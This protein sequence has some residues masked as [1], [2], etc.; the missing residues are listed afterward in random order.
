MTTNYEW[1]VSVAQPGGTQ[2]QTDTKGSTIAEA[3]ANASEERP[4]D[5]VIVGIRRGSPIM[6]TRSVGAV[7]PKIYAWADKTTDHMDPGYVL[8]AVAEDGTVIVNDVHKGTQIEWVRNCLKEGTKAHAACEYAYPDGF[9][10]VWIDN[11]G[12]HWDLI[13]ARLAAESRYL[14]DIVRPGVFRL[15]TRKSVVIGYVVHR[16]DLRAV[17]AVPAAEAPQPDDLLPD[18]PYPNYALAAQF[19]HRRYRG[20]TPA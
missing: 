8:H 17:Y 15:S 2:Y 4:Q 10:M 5:H 18:P 9:E 1:I 14:M 11:P 16:A 6:A 7:T 20:E 13:L 3:L 19:L 12:N